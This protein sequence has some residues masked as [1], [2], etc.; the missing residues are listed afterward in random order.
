M[1]GVSP[2]RTD[3]ACD[4]RSRSLGVLRS[5][6]MQQ[7]QAEQG[8]LADLDHVVPRADSLRFPEQE[9][10]CTSQ[11]WGCSNAVLELRCSLSVARE[12]PECEVGARSHATTVRAGHRVLTARQAMGALHRPS[13]RAG[14]LLTRPQNCG[15]FALRGHR[16]A[17]APSRRT[18]GTDSSTFQMLQSHVEAHVT[19]FAGAS[20]HFY[21][22]SRSVLEPLSRKLRADE[23][24]TALVVER[25]VF[26]GR[27][28][29]RLVVAASRLGRQVGCTV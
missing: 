2:P 6:L 18:C 19:L 15:E 28:L 24:S 17:R 7:Q 4:R 11:S 29:Q 27:S 14:L 16:T 3:S 5:T 22:G 23:H 26:R 13:V 1:C 10:L 25:G 9:R 21:G 12:G 8:R 20:S